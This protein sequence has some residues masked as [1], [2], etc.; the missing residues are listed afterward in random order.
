MCLVT[1][2]H[3]HSVSGTKGKLDVDSPSDTDAAVMSQRSDTLLQLMRD[4]DAVTHSVS[5]SSSSSSSGLSSSHSSTH[6]LER[7][8]PVLQDGGISASAW[9]AYFDEDGHLNQWDTVKRVLF[10]RGADPSV[11]AEVFKFLFEEFKV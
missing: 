6:H 2:N 8:P 7:E 5:S 1:R 11:R 10:F 4:D 9:G 3:G